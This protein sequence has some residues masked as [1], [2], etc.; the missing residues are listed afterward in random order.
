[1]FI[2]PQDLVD[3]GACREGQADVFDAEWP[4]GV[5]V[6]R[7]SLLRAREL[8]LDLYFLVD[9]FLTPAQQEAYRKGIA[10][11]LEAYE[12]A[13]ALLWEAYEKAKA[14]VIADILGCE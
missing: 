4:D 9:E 6:T 7:E 11:H 13:K 10:P 3:K 12:K 5:E 8:G 14:N 2:T 1:M